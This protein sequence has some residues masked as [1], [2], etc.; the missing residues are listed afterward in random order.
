MFLFLLFDDAKLV[1]LFDM[2][3]YILLNIVNETILSEFG[4]N[5]RYSTYQGYQ[6]FPD[7]KESYLL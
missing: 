2:T 6:A 4:G 3:K 7:R 1:T 5:I